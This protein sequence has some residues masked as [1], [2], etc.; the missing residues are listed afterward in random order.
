MKIIDCCSYKLQLQQGNFGFVWF[1]VH[2]GDVKPQWGHWGA[3]E[4]W[5]VFYTL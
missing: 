3:H 4:K 1:G 2:G 5:P